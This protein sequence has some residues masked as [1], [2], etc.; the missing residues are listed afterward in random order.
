MFRSLIIDDD[1]KQRVVLRSRLE[2][3]CADTIEIIGEADS[4]KSA[5]KAIET[6]CPDLVF[7]DIDLGNGQTG[8]DV[9]DATEY[10]DFGVIFVTAFPQ[11]FQKANTYNPLQFLVKPISGE[12]LQVIVPWV[13]QVLNSNEV[14]PEGEL[15]FTGATGTLAFDVGRE[16]LTFDAATVLFC[17]AQGNYTELTEQQGDT[18]K[19]HTLRILLKDLDELFREHGFLRVHRSALVNVE[20]IRTVERGNQKIT[21]TMENGAKVSVSK[22]YKI[23]LLAALERRK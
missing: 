5:V 13:V 2:K 18:F 4:L 14:T 9:L 11:Y 8:F 23:A 21:L 7:L 15:S 3:Y 17:E 20:H 1:T 6:H 19:T 16:T 10:D 12:Q 22:T